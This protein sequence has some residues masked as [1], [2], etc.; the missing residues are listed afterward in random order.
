MNGMHL[1]CKR[2]A[3]TVKRHSTVRMPCPHEYAIFLSYHV[4]SHESSSE[5]GESCSQKVYQMGCTRWKSSL[6]LQNEKNSGPS[7]ARGPVARYARRA[8]GKNHVFGAFIS[9]F[10]VIGDPYEALKHSEQYL[11]VS[12]RFGW[13]MVQLYNATQHV[14]CMYTCCGHAR[15]Q[16][17]PISCPSCDWLRAC[18]ESSNPLF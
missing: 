10:L 9:V 16:F 8:P 17:G 5:P 14:Y 13:L 7:A 15:L 4:P 6:A 1:T 2:T 3:T 12:P 18:P 11:N